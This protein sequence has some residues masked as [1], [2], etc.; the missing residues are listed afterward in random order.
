MRTNKIMR[1]KYILR[2]RETVI[3]KYT[4]LCI[5]VCRN[6]FVTV[7]KWR[8]HFSDLLKCSLWYVV[9]WDIITLM[10]TSPTFYVLLTCF[11]VVTSERVTFLIFYT[12][13]TSLV[14]KQ[15]ILFYE[16]LHKK[17]LV[18]SNYKCQVNVV[19]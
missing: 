11:T 6:T 4:S 3:Y 14:E 13:L 12:L 9:L 18:K 10:A 5:N 8:L 7:W 15:H 17:I 2:T 16:V 19:E 1:I